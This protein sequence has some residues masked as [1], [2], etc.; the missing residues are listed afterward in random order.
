MGH[1]FGKYAKFSEKTN[2]FY[3][4]SGGKKCQFFGKLCVRTKWMTSK[5]AW[6]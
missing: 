6:I 5:E 4:V 2:V 1:E 3:R